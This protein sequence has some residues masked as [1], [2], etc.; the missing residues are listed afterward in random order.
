MHIYDKRQKLCSLQNCVFNFLALQIIGSSN[1]FF[2]YLFKSQENPVCHYWPSLLNQTILKWSWLH[3]NVSHHYFSCSSPI[4]LT[5]PYSFLS[6][7]FSQPTP[8]FFSFF[9]PSNYVTG[10][11]ITWV[12]RITLTPHK[13]VDAD[14]SVKKN[15]KLCVMTSPWQP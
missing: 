4:L 9:F 5:L 10:K 3:L 8:S 12:I 2:F 6:H 7:S 15:E 13:T 14:W 11:S 1:I